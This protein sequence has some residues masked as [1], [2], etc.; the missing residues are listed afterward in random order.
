M[1]FAALLCVPA[2]LGYCA[3]AWAAETP[4]PSLSGRVT[5]AVRLPGL[6]YLPSRPAPLSPKAGKPA[7]W[8]ELFQRNPGLKQRLDA[9]KKARPEIMDWD[10]LLRMPGRPPSLEDLYSQYPDLETFIPRK[11]APPSGPARTR[12]IIQEGKPPVVL[13]LP[14][15]GLNKLPLYKPS[16][17]GVF[18]FQHPL[19]TPDTPV[20]LTAVVPEPE[21]T[22]I[23]ELPV[24]SRT[25]PKSP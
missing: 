6:P 21:S 5:A 24:P 20:N 9:L 19:L 22:G 16:D 18:K 8:D 12:I 11:F 23:V 2:T 13:A 1:K 17:R 14:P 15:A 4:V 3:T 7:T 10:S 25:D